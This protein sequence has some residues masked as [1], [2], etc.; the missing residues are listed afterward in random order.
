MLILSTLTLLLSNSAA[1]RKDLSTFFS[2]G[3]I[4]ILGIAAFL[5]F[6]NLN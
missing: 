4:T 1:L 6:T 3:T 5:A 2:R